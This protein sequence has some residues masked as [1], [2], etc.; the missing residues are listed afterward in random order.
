MQCEATSREFLVQRGTKQGDPISPLIF[1][2]VLKEVMRKVKAKWAKRKYGIQLGSGEQAI[3][4]NLRFADD[5]VLIAR[6][7]PQLKQML[8]DVHHECRLA[9]L[10]LHPDKTKIQHN[11]IGY[12]SGVKEVSVGGMRINVLSQSES[13]L[14]LGR[15]LS[16]TDA[17]E[18][19]LDHR[20]RRAWAKFGEFKDELT[21]KEIP[22]HLRMKLFQSVVTPTAM[23][24][25]CSWTMISSRMAKLQGTQR[26][27]LR[28][29]LG[30]R[31]LLTA[32]GCVETWVEWVQ[33]VTH[34][35]RKLAE[36]HNVSSWEDIHSARMRQWANR[37]AET[38]PSRWVNRVLSWDPDGGRRRGRPHT[39][40]ADQ[41]S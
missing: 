33:R 17:H 18:A 31:R 28:A 9:G 38:S 30:R 16:L 13:I 7:L 20:L 29:I 27:M 41:L 10:E 25:C 26:K 35:A 40:W 34:E 3:L 22:L 1:N 32:D 15:A 2:S 5:V 36:T 14:Y 24:G 39:R 4:T 6:S 21:N 23:Y 11:H 19:E 37:L 12:G 8:A